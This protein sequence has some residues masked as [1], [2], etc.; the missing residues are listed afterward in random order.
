MSYKRT[1][2]GWL[3]HIRDGHLVPII[4]DGKV[5]GVLDIAR[6]FSEAVKPKQKEQRTE[7][8]MR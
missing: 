6:L 5:V 1:F 4:K 3:N 7:I 8:G 2:I